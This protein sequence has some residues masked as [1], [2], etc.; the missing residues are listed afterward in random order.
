V[1][2]ELP[3]PPEALGSPS[4]EMIRVWLANQQQHIVLNI[5]FW[6]ERGID[7]RAAW[8]VVLADMVHHIAD[9]HEAE[10]GHDPQES[11]AKIRAAF[12]AEMD[13]ATSERQGGFH[14]ERREESV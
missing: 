10:Y 11:I 13:S 2:N 3:I 1:A 4:V 7:E 9:A 8:G 6:E 12:E 14:N 5:G